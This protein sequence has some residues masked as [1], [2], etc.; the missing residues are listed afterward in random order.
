MNNVATKVAA[1]AI[2]E[3]R[4][5][6]QIVASSRGRSD[7][8]A[9]KMSTAA[10]VGMAT[11]PTIPANATRMTTIQMPDQIAA[12]RVRA[13]AATLSAVW[14]T[15]P[16]TGWPRN[17]PDARFPTPC[18]TKSR[19][20]FDGRPS[21]FGAASPTPAPCTSTITATASA[22]T[23]RSNDIRLKSGSDGAGISC[24]IAPASSTR[25]TL[26]APATT[27]ASVGM[28]SATNALTVFKR[29]RARPK[30]MTNA[31]SPVSN[32]A[33]RCCPGG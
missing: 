3:I 14:P 30:R 2:C 17:R 27:T 28:I 32:E 8:I 20:M 26:S 33:D 10:S 11:L 13:P 18:A 15:E 4:P 19:F 16:P 29:V 22:S 23:T 25:A 9:A 21:A 1:I 6:R 5:V 31:P 7:P 24:G 12:H